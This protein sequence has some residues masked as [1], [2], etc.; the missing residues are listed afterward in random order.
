MGEGNGNNRRPELRLIQGG[1]GSRQL[2]SVRR[3]GQSHPPTHGDESV[4]QHLRAPLG[5]SETNEVTSLR[6]GWVFFEYSD[7]GNGEVPAHFVE[8]PTV[9]PTDPRSP[10]ADVLEPTEEVFDPMIRS[11]VSVVDT[12]CSVPMSAACVNGQQYVVLHK[13]RSAA[14]TTPTTTIHGKMHPVDARRLSLGVVA[15]DLIPEAIRGGVL[16]HLE[17]THHRHAHTSQEHLLSTPSGLEDK[18]WLEIPRFRVSFGALVDSLFNGKSTHGELHVPMN[19]P[20]DAVNIMVGSLALLELLYG[21]RPVIITRSEDSNGM[22]QLEQEVARLNGVLVRL[23]LDTSH[24][25]ALHQPTPPAS[26][27][28]QWLLKRLNE[29]NGVTSLRDELRE[30]LPKFQNG[31]LVERLDAVYNRHAVIDE[32][33]HKI[34]EQYR[35]HCYEQEQRGLIEKI[36][37][38]HTLATTLHRALRTLERHYNAPYRRLW[39]GRQTFTIA[40]VAE[41][42]TME[43]E[44]SIS[45]LRGHLQTLESAIRIMLDQ[46]SEHD[47]LILRTKYR[48]DLPMH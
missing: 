15:L 31:S 21:D 2:E 43:Y 13:E 42:Q 41:L 20:A 26:A 47:N 27:L 36:R 9:A 34:A 11:I 25:P 48:I 38:Q 24:D 46:I 12:Q 45:G 14:A 30:M 7:E 1:K 10:S 23:R 44:P 32:D 19:N 39:R 22:E 35:Q 28:G 18:Q 40:P 17:Y 33:I 8:T 29:R 16:E 5:E 3:G 6:H 37:S 4:T